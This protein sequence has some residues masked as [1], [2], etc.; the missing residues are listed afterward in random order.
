VTIEVFSVNGK[1]LIPF[2][3]DLCLLENI[4]LSG[5]QRIII[6]LSI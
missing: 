5:F 3:K 2:K 1:K 4:L 6:E